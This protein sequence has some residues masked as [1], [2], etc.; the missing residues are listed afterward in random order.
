MS[1]RVLW[2]RT[3]WEGFGAPRVLQL[4]I[5]PPCGEGSGP[6]RVLRSSVG[7]EP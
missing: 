6:P 7:H 1:P 4:H 2:L 5:L 3:R